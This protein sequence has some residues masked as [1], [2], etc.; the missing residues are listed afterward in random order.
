MKAVLFVLYIVNTHGGMEIANPMASFDS[1]Y[2]SKEVCEAKAK[3]G[4]EH[5][6]GFLK[7]V[8]IPNTFERAE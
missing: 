5:L 7:F 2:S 6:P 4:N 1:A 8:C 3:A